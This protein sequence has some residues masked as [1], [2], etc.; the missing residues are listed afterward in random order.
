MLKTII[1][2]IAYMVQGYTMKLFCLLLIVI[3]F[4]VYVL[5]WCDLVKHGL[6]GVVYLVVIYFVSMFFL[7]TEVAE[8]MNTHH[9]QE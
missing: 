6:L 5:G 2:I 7:S 1:H 3:P 9:E 8:R 4:M